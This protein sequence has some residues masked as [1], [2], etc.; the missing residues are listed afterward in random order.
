M[1]Q[2]HIHLP[3]EKGE[4]VPLT[5]CR[6]PDDPTKCKSDFPRTNWLIEEAVVLC[7]GLL[8]KMGLAS[9]GRR[10]K[11]GSLHGPMNHDSL[12][13]SASA[14][15]SVQQFNSDVQIPYRLPVCE[16]T[17]SRLCCKDCLGLCSADDEAAMIQATQLAQDAQCGYTCD[18][19]SKR[20]PA[21]FNEVKEFCKGQHDLSS[22]VSKEKISYIGKRHASRFMSDAYGKGIVRG[23]AENTNLRAYS[24]DNAVTHAETFRT[25]LTESFC[26]REYLK[27]VETLNDSRPSDDAATFAEIDSRNPM[28]KKIT[29]RDVAI[30]YGQ[31]PKHNDVWHLSP[32]EFVMHWQPQLCSYPLSAADEQLGDH[33]VRMTDGGSHKLLKDGSDSLIPGRDYVVKDGGVNW[34]AF[35]DCPGSRHF[36]HTWVLVRRKRPVTPTFMGAPVPKHRPGE[37]QRAAAIAMAYFHPWTLRQNDADQHVKYAGQLRGSNEPWQDALQCWLDG[38]IV[39]EEA[40]KYVSNFLSVHRMRPRDDDE[41]DDGNSQD[42]AS[43][44]ELEISRSELMDALTTRIGGK[45]NEEC[46]ADAG[47]GL[48]HFQNSMAAIALNQ[49][50]WRTNLE[51]KSAKVHAVVEPEALQKILDAAKA[52]QKREHVYDGLGK[53]VNQSDATLRQLVSATDRDVQAWLK[54]KEWKLI[55]MASEF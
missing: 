2:H 1:K 39:C 38:N 46:D 50:I 11:L 16:T 6:R 35:P 52:S 10:N 20:Q 24:Q 55:R 44:E 18:Y 48:T 45:G 13:G 5:H 23:Q 26:G 29:I 53:D 7:H 47:G 12:N 41:S 15:L 21:A 28:K 42:I 36:R 22:K 34:L 3:N 49:N 32:Y 40:A 51:N 25:S 37:Q 8:E 19:C 30:L 14:L 43:D 33:H 9:S 54:K 17:H 31:R 27:V 4:R